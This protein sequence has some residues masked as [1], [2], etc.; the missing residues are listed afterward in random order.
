MMLLLLMMMMTLSV[1]CAAASLFF[2][3]PLKHNPLVYCF[4]RNKEHGTRSTWVDAR[5]VLGRL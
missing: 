2:H 3:V 5:W 1:V 4:I